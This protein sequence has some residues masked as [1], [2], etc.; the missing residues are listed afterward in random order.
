MDNFFPVF[1]ATPQVDLEM[2]I[3]EWF[4]VR[5]SGSYQFVGDGKATY[6]VFEEGGLVEKEFNTRAV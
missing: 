5:L 6:E 4:K 3:T 2:N 1:V